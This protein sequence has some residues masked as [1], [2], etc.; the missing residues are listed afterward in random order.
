MAVKKTLVVYCTH[1]HERVGERVAARLR[2]LVGAHSTGSGQVVE[3]VAG[4]PEALARSVAFIESDLNRVFPGRPDGT[5]E[6]RRAAELSPSILEAET[7]FDIHSTSANDLG[8]DSMLIVTKLDGPTRRAIEAIAP[9]KVIVMGYKSGHALISQAR[10]GIAFE[11]GQDQS[12]R[13][14]DAIVHDLAAALLALGAVSSNPFPNPRPP[15]GETK[16]FEV[17]DVFPKTSAG[18]YRLAEGCRNFESCRAGAP[19][20]EFLDTGEIV[21][22]TEDFVPILFGEKR[23]TDIFGFKARPVGSEA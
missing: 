3:F 9:P 23:Y 1:G 8:E 21:Y 20:C 12:P 5:L 6:E 16:I 19:V 2:P 15:S 10:V 4:N 7:V 17:Y 11:Y 13:V 22:A 14:E 18:A